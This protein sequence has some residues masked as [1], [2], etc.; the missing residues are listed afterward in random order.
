M[1]FDI[2][3]GGLGGQGLQLATQ[4]LAQ[5]AT[6]E[7]KNVLQYCDYT[8]EMRGGKIDCTV[9]VAPAGEEIG[10]P[11]RPHPRAAVAMSARAW[12]EY[13]ETVSVGGVLILNTSIVH[14]AAG[15]TDVHVLEVPTLRLAEEIGEPRAIS[16]IALGALISRTGVVSLEMAVEALRLSL[17]PHRQTLIAANEKA[18]RRGAAFDT[19]AA[20]SVP[21]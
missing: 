14:G 6:L 8:S 12:Q 10:S 9:V 4:V 5:A 21:S 2:L 19:A 11:R 3:F 7:G 20:A 16:M 15:R 13:R 18:L 1:E 17:P